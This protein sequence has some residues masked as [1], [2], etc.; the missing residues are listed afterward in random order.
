MRQCTSILVLAAALLAGGCAAGS[1]AVNDRGGNSGGI[2]FSEDILPLLQ[3]R[4]QPLLED[5]D[6]LD[7]SSWESLI[8]GSNHGEVLIPFDADRSVL[9]E[10][11]QNRENDL[12]PDEIGLVRRWIEQGARNDEGS[13]PYEDADQLLYVCN[14]GSSVISVIDMESNLVVRTVDL[15]DLG[16]SANSKPHHIAVSRD[17]SYW[18]VSLIG[19]NTVL[20]LNRDNEIIG[21]VSFDVPGM[22]ALDRDESTLFVG[23]SMSAVNPPHSIGMI[24]TE[25]MELEVIDVFFPRPHALDV[26]ADGEFV[27]VASLAV[28]QMASLN[29]ETL[30]IEVHELPA[31]DVHHHMPMQFE[32]APD[33]RTMIVGGEMSGRL[34]FYDISERMEPTVT[35]SITLGGS[36]WNPT[37]TPDGR[38]AYVPLKRGAAVAVVDMEAREQIALVEGPGLSE[39]DGAATRPDGRFVYVTNSNLDGTYSPR[40]DYDGGPNGTVVVIDTSTNQVVKVIEVE[41]NPTGI[42]TRPPR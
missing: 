38:F 13:V 39:P 4:Y 19:D 2:V 15:E 40:H 14:Q 26:T 16:F 25:S 3:T 22:L 41:E 21:R 8:E 28:D 23:R 18:F 29:T 1:G 5:E 37:Y 34:L 9:I 6:G 12:T 27:Y 31:G 11:A 33:E 24:D 20:K 32:I 10:L 7:L 36:P 42:G 30:D 35:E 17:G